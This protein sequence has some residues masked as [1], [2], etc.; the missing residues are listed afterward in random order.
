MFCHSSKFHVGDMTK[1]IAFF[2]WPGMFGIGTFM[3]DIHD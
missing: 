2:L 1:M 3:I